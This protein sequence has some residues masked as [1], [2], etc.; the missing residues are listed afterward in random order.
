MVGGCVAFGAAV[1]PFF[2][3]RVPVPDGFV[4][5]VFVDRAV[6]MDRALIL[7]IDPG[8]TGFTGRIFQCQSRGE[9]EESE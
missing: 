2:L 8:V 6:G 7:G 4:Q 3:V 9:T 1:A 5:L